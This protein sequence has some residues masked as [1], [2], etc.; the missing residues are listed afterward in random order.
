VPDLEIPVN[1]EDVTFET[2]PAI[3]AAV[4]HLDK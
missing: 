2:D 3:Q 1:W 4:D